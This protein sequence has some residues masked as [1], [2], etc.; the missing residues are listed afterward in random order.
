[1]QECKPNFDRDTPSTADEETGGAGSAP[2]GRSAQASGSFLT[3]AAWGMF[4]ISIWAGWYITTRLDV[5]G[6]LTAYDLVALRFGISA[7]VLFP[8]AI[9]LRLGLAMVSLPNALAIFAG[10]G[11]IYSLCSTWGVAFAPAADGA[12]LTPGVMPMATA[13]LSV[14]I[15]KERLTGRQLVGFALIMGGVAAI[16]G[17]GFFAGAPGQWAGDLL[18]V[19]GAWLFAGYTIA[20]RRSGLTGL[21]AVALV[22]V[23]SCALYLPVYF[24][25]FHPRLFEVPVRALIFPA[26]YQGILTNVVSLVAYG[27]A[28]RLLGAS[29]AAPFAALIPAMTAVLGAVILNELPSAVGWAGVAAVSAGVFLAS[30]SRPQNLGRP[31]N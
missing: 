20:L 5:T 24:L 27:R 8:L 4:A 3:G 31:A 22:S 25:W 13:I 2:A 7:L 21:R 11:V 10:S 28:V 14:L 29:R 9:R 12:A 26:V 23:W 30:W 17:L 6:G 1:M 18:F 15:L 19:A 16:G